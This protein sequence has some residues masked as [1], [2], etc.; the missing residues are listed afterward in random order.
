MQTQID[1]QPLNTMEAVHE[2]AEVST[3]D[4][5]RNELI[6]AGIM[7]LVIE[8]LSMMTSFYGLTC[9]IQLENQRYSKTYII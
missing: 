5:R 2:L 3:R 8:K 6:S 4:Y 1:K 7:E 9:L